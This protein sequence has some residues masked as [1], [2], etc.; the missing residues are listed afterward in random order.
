MPRIIQMRDGHDY[1]LNCRSIFGLN[2]LDANGIKVGTEDDPR[3]I[4]LRTLG[5]HNDCAAHTGNL[6]DFADNPQE[7]FGAP[8]KEHIYFLTRVGVYGSRFYDT[9][10]WSTFPAC[11]FPKVNDQFWR[12]KATGSSADVE[13]IVSRDALA[14]YVGAS[15]NAL[16]KV[17]A[18]LNQPYSDQEQWLKSV[19]SFY[20]LIILSG[21][22]GWYFYVYTRDPL[23]YELL[24]PAISGAIQAVE[25][26]DWYRE[27]AKTLQWDEQYGL[28][29]RLPQL[30]PKPTI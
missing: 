15:G 16:N 8:S 4:F 20:S 12:I 7:F 2:I 11:F 26:T 6:Y 10:D 3:V 22:D 13:R 14:L 27:N 29:L 5:A 25:R 9:K 23:F 19:A 1:G 17:K 21:G 24:T 30:V 28:C 18:L